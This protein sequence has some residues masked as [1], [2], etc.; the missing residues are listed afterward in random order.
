MLDNLKTGITIV[1][2]VGGALLVLW[3]GSILLL[4]LA[5][6]AREEYRNAKAK[7]RSWFHVE[8][9]LD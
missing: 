2:S 3:L 5:Y 8:H 7:I 4:A 9:S 6:A 1:Y